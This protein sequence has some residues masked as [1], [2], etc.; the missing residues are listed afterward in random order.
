M[1]SGRTI[2][3]VAVALALSAGTAGLAAQKASLPATVGD[4]NTAQLIE[5]RDSTGQVLLNGTLKTSSNK[6]KETERKADLESPTGQKGEGELE[7]EIERK[8]GVVVTKDEVELEVEHLPAM[9]SCALFIDGQH[10]AAFTTSKSGK[11]KVKL[12]RKPASGK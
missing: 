3:V 12:E 8:D 10:I 1:S 7:V 2:A 4:L 6:P 9:T 5:V 11:A